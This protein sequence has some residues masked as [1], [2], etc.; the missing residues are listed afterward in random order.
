MLQNKYVVRIALIVAL[1]GFLMGFDASVISGVN[2]FIEPY[3]DLTKIQLGWAV[4]SLTLTATLAMLVA[5][6]LSDAYGRKKVF[7][8]TA[9]PEKNSLIK[10]APPVGGAFIGISN[11]PCVDPVVAW[12]W[13][14]LTFTC[15]TVP[16]TGDPSNIGLQVLLD[17]KPRACSKVLG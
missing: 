7:P 2:E 1:G 4:S 8:P 12:A 6:P 15:S 17:A 16:C 5:G 10:K 13:P 11:K 3:F 9:G 14:K